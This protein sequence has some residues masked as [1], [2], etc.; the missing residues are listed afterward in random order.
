MQ[1]ARKIFALLI[2]VFGFTI[3]NGCGDGNG[4]DDLDTVK[5]AVLWETVGQLDG[6]DITEIAYSAPNTYAATAENLYWLNGAKWEKVNVG[7]GTDHA[8][9]GEKVA[10]AGVSKL[11]ALSGGRLVA[12]TTAKDV[13]IVKAGAITDFWAPG[14]GGAGDTKIGAE[15]ITD[16]AVVKGAGDQEAIIITDGTVTVKAQFDTA[17]F[18]KEWD[19]TFQAFDKGFDKEMT[20]LVVDSAGNLFIGDSE[21]FGFYKIEKAKIA[22]YKKGATGETTTNLG[23]F[24]LSGAKNNA[25]WGDDKLPDSIVFTSDVAVVSANNKTGFLAVGEIK[26]D[27]AAVEIKDNGADIEANSLTLEGDQVLAFTDDGYYTIDNKGALVGGIFA[28]PAKDAEYVLKTEDEFK[29]LTKAKLPLFAGFASKEI[30]SAVKAGDKTYYIVDKN[31][32]VKITK[33]IKIAK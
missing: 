23:T 7:V 9:K 10:I 17:I 13:I 21:Q 15:A 22:T 12:T 29:K 8:G 31:V 3:A 33:D 28:G 5:Q 27:G 32:Y 26:K 11:T 18:K 24:A 25:V 16:I 6:K 2:A 19:V 30:S 4:N 1:N 20:T 14:K